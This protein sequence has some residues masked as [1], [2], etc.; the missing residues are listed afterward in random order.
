MDSSPEMDFNSPEFAAALA[1]KAVDKKEEKAKESADETAEKDPGSAPDEAETEKESDEKEESSKEEDKDES[2]P[3][4]V[5]ALRKELKRV[6]AANREKDEKLESLE[7]KV[8]QLAEKSDTKE[9]SEKD[10]QVVKLTKMSDPDFK[11]VSNEW[12]DEL[13]DATAKLHVAQARGDAEAEESAKQRVARAKVAQDLLDEAK[14]KRA[15]VTVRSKEKEDEERGHIEE[16]LAAIQDDFLKTLPALKDHESD[17]FKAGEREYN[18]HRALMSKMGPMGQMLAVAL[19]IIRNPKLVGR[20]AVAA[21]KELINN[22][23]EAASKALDTG[24]KGGT[25]G[26]GIQMPEPGTQSFEDFIERLKSGG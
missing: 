23:E 21:R 25:K 18:R 24:V 20:D 11:R 26:K 9:L 19:A 15:E 7:A 14:E 5:K 13:V 17:A 4:S 6:R 3:S 12:R 10:R 2:E 1:G 8:N 22:V 16:S